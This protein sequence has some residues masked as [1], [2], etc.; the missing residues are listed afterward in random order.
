MATR[1]RVLVAL[2]PPEPILEPLRALRSLVGA[3]SVERI[4]PH[5]TLV[6]PLNL[7]R[8]DAELR[9]HLRDA[10]RDLRPFELWLGP[11]ASF[12]PENP[13]LH[14]RVG[15][16]EAAT[17]ALVQLRQRLRSDVL[18]REDR[19]G[20]VPHLTLRRGAGSAATAAAAEVLAGRLG[21][22]QVDRIHLLDQVHDERGTAWSV[23]AE[24][25]FGG[26]VVVGRGGVELHLRTSS[27]AERLVGEAEATTS[28]ATGPLIVVA[29]L[30]STPGE[31]V[32][33]AV[34]SVA[35]DD[36]R[37]LDLAVVEAHRGTGIGRQV[38]AH[39][40]SE[41][42]SR[43]ATVAISEAPLAGSGL[44][45]SSGWSGSGSLAWRRL[46]VPSG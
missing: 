38:L 5:V 3:P 8:S 24:E 27:T 21:P 26:P 13:T 30:P 44:L 33:R 4:T 22:W 25:P 7:R 9:A 6:P 39:W 28:P 43:G 16:D 18:D 34:G 17:D 37:L 32:A 19:H 45:V 46:G 15:G 1:R 11:G 23:S 10:V 40:C 31:V 12:A 35:G 14:L 20:F 29:E 36:A 2:V 41:A 42:A